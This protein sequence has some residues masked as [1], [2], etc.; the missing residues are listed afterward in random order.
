MTFHQMFNCLK[1]TIASKLSYNGFFQLLIGYETGLLTL[2]D[3]K[4]KVAEC[5]F[6]CKEVSFKQLFILLFV[7]MHYDHFLL[8]MGIKFCSMDL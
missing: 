8:A 4:S 7:E 6:N 2:W 3:L 1:S 5:Q